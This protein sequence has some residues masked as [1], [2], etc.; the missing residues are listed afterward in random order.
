M[1]Y[2]P[3]GNSGLH[4]S[5]VGLGCNNFGTRLDLAGTKSVID[6]AID[7]GVTLLDTADI[8]GK[9]ASEELIGQALE[10]RRDQVVIATKWGNQNSDMGYGP[11]AGALGGRAYIRRAVEASLT[12]LRTDHIDLYQL[13]T[14]DPSTPI[15]E[16]LAALT[17]LVA[18][19]KV[20]Y[21]G[22]SNFAGWQ[23]ADAEHVARQ[24]GFVRFISAQNHYSLL[25]RETETEIVP[26]SQA[27]GIGQLPFFPLANGLLT[28]KVRRDTGAP[29]D[30]RLA[31]RDAYL[32]EDK[33][34]RVEAL[35]KWGA[36]H[37]HTLLEIA[38]AGL[39]AQ[40]TV[41]SVIAGATKPEQVRANAAA[42]EWI[43][44]SEELAEINRLAP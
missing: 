38:I 12:R 42:A 19:G 36:E 24:N 11:S 39:L 41:A 31:G 10:G 29:A 37:G 25:E 40:P 23:I 17:E 30:S 27:F 44:T 18:E 14:P 20:L 1:R 2:Q 7:V 43:P 15:E 3:L 32:T 5:V 8:Y 9:G 13:H 34:D 28:G 22:S 35:E 6:A 16:T 21:V 26:A 4:V 33:F